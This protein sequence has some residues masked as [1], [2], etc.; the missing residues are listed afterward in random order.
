MT[1][2]IKRSFCNL[3]YC[4]Y[5]S[6]SLFFIH[7]TNCFIWFIY[8]YLFWLT[9]INTC[10]LVMHFPVFLT[11]VGIRQIRTWL[12]TWKANSFYQVS[13]FLPTWFFLPLQKFKTIKIKPGK[14]THTQT[15]RA[16]Y[17]FQGTSKT[18]SICFTLYLKQTVNNWGSVIAFIDRCCLPCFFFNRY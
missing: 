17:I 5:I 18:F 15:I 11:H 6:N 16:C 4:T 2:L 14:I 7:C 8:L 10:E 3:I 12:P 13:T 1:S 9:L